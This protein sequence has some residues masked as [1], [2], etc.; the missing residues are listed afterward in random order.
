MAPGITWPRLPLAA[1]AYSWVASHASAGWVFALPPLGLVVAV[2]V[3]VA[4]GRFLDRPDNDAV[5]SAPA[6]AGNR[7]TP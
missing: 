3:S 4:C 5:D 7:A 2:V 6:S 1:R